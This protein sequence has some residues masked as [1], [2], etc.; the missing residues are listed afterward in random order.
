MSTQSNS[1]FDQLLHIQA[2]TTVYLIDGFDP[3]VEEFRSDERDNL[4]EAAKHAHDSSDCSNGHNDDNDDQDDDDV[5]DCSNNDDDNQA[6][7]SSV[8]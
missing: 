7:E 6:T 2:A 8:L 3:V 4:E 5:I 1:H